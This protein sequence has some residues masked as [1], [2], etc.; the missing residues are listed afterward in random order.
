MDSKKSS[1]ASALAPDSEVA[2]EADIAAT[3]NAVTAAAESPSS[4]RRRSAR[5]SGAAAA[6]QRSDVRGTVRQGKRSAARAPNACTIG[7][8]GG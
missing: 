3:Q 8:R 4:R 6:T 5:R 2:T 1:G 7:T